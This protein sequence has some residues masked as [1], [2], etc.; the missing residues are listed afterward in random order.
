MAFG[1][2]KMYPV[3]SDD[4][5]LAGERCR[6]YRK[7]WNLSQEEMG[8]TLNTQRVVVNRLEAGREVSTRV[9]RLALDLTMTAAPVGVDRTRRAAT[10]TTGLETAAVEA[11]LAAG[12]A[13]AA[14][15]VEVEDADIP[16]K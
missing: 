6:E 12:P 11:R 8:L 1:R 10:V 15:V 16:F 2:R 3:T 9:V 4:R 7:R 5:K 14:P 13:P